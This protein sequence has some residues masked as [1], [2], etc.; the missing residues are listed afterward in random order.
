MKITIIN[1]L[2]LLAVFVATAFIAWKEGVH[3]ASDKENIKHK[4]DFIIRLIVVCVS[5]AVFHTLT[6]WELGIV[7]IVVSGALLAITQAFLYWIVFE[8]SY[9]DADGKSEFYIGKTA[10]TDKAVR[11][12][13]ITGIAY[14]FIKVA[15]F[16]MFGTF[17]VLWVYGDHWS[18]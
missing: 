17:Y 16:M 8:Y 12:L 6:L 11:R 3:D 14:F 1:A 7:A 4:R 9:N 15:G 10:E 18:I 5:N 2:F 13:N